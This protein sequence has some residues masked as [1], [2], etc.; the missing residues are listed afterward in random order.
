MKAEITDLDFAR[1][2]MNFAERK[3]F[4]AR[5]VVGAIESLRRRKV[6]P[7]VFFPALALYATILH[8]FQSP[9]PFFLTFILIHT[10]FIV[11]DQLRIRRRFTR[12]IEA[13]RLANASA[14]TARETRA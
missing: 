6:W 3:T 1:S 8:I 7:L 4:D 9:S 11:L 13:A 12:A 10:G 2:Q 5:D 14:S